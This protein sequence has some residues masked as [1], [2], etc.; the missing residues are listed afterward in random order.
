MLMFSPVESPAVAVFGRLVFCVAPPVS[1]DARCSMDRLRA[2]IGGVSTEVVGFDVSESW[3]ERVVV[4]SLS[5][6]L[7]MLTAPRLIEAIVRVAGQEPTA[8]IVDLTKVQFL[9]SA[10]LNALVAAHLDITPSARFGIV[11]EGV[12]VRRPLRLTG[13]DTLVVLFPTLDDALAS[14]AVEPNGVTT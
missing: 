6:E 4:L 13:I 11:A 9:A 2:L 10:G 5:G 8:M 7:D 14:F 1:T 12:A 3:T